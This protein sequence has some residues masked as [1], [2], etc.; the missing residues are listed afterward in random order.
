MI[1]WLSLRKLKKKLNS[2]DPQLIRKFSFE[3]LHCLVKVVKVY[4]GDTCTLIFDRKGEIIK[5]SCRLFGIDTPEIR[6]R[7][8]EEKKR[9]YEAKKFLEYLVLDDIIYCE[10]L[11]ND[12]YG[13]PLVKLFTKD[14]RLVSNVL[15]QNGY[16]KSYYGGTKEK[17][18]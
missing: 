1:N 17:F 4:D 9:G 3:G 15:I 12:K 11:E 10:F 5:V 6:T 14:N 2:V 18:S 8:D 13:R 16:A 7:N